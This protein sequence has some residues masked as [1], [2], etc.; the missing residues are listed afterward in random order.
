VSEIPKKGINPVSTV[1]GLSVIILLMQ[2]KSRELENRITTLEKILAR[3]RLQPTDACG[4]RPG[5]RTPRSRK[6]EGF[7]L[8]MKPLCGW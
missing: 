3:L 1:V 8:V 2:F 6:Q 7:P 4:L 5:R